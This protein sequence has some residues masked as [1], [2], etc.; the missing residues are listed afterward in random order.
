MTKHCIK[1]GNIA[2]KKISI[3]PYF[4]KF[5]SS[6]KTG[7]FLMIKSFYYTGIKEHSKSIVSIL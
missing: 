3:V 1:G 2:M 6:G 5:K 4:T 7:T